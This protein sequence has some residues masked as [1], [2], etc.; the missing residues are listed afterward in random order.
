MKILINESHFKE[1]V[2][3]YI[4]ESFK[5][6]I[7]DVFFQGKMIE[8]IVP[9]E[10][11][12]KKENKIKSEIYDELKNMFG[13]GFPI[14]VHFETRFYA[15]LEFDGDEESGY[16]VT[17]TKEMDNG[18]MFELTGQIK[19]YDSGRDIDYEFEPDDISNEDYYSDNWEEIENFILNKFYYR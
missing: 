10:G 19:E 15:N 8:V 1:I 18:E 6:K 17:F 3:D 4:K 14:D 11:S 13:K 16:K 7:S 12:F 5:D 9:G 2:I